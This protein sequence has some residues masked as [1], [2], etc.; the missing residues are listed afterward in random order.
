MRLLLLITVLFYGF[1]GFGQVPRLI[2]YQGVARDFMGVPIANSE[3]TIQ[4]S[5]HDNVVVV[6]TETQQTL[7][8]QLGLFSINVGAIIPLEIDW[9][10]PHL[11][12]KTEF[13]ISPNSSFV[14]LGDEPIGTIPFALMAENI[15]ENPFRVSNWG[16]SLIFNGN[17]FIIIPGL[18]LSNS[19]A[20]LFG[21][22]YLGACN[23]NPAAVYDD[24]SCYFISQPCND[25][26]SATL[27][28][29]INQ[30]CEC[31]GQ[32]LGCTNSSACNFN[33]LASADDGT[34]AGVGFLC[35]DGNANTINDLYQADCSCE[36]TYVIFGC[37]QSNACN[38]NPLANYDNGTC[39][40]A[41]QPCNDNNSATLIDIINQNCECVGQVLGCTN[42]SACNFNPLANTDDGA[43]A[44][45]GFLCNDGN[46]N[47]TNDHYLNDCTC[48]GDVVVLGCMQSNACN[49]NAFANVDNGSC[50][51]YGNTC[52]DGN[53]NTPNDHILSNCECH[54]DNPPNGNG[55]YTPGNG[56][57]DYDGNYYPSV[58][59]GNQEWLASN[60]KTT[61]YCDGTPIAQMQ[62]NTV[63]S[64]ALTPGWCYFNNDP[65]NNLT[66]GKLYNNW[67][68]DNDSLN[69][70]PCGWHMPS[71][72][73]WL[74]LRSFLGGQVPAG[75]KMRSSITWSNNSG[76]NESG[77]N[78]LGGGFRLDNGTFYD[79]P[80][81]SVYWWQQKGCG[82]YWQE[83]PNIS[84]N[85]S[86]GFQMVINNW[87]NW[88]NYIRC[89]K[90]E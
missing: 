25:N 34:C 21:C 5:I 53:P 66:F 59:I 83:M 40:F 58:I 44:G 74:E 60:L 38:F 86:W 8:N 19:N 10:L 87:V 46:A 11:Q 85:N 12:L 76:T 29:I 28:D 67:T 31:V 70:C 88:G 50:L 73:E 56:A 65:N 79:F 37:T 63:W 41:G 47:T 17:Q 84:S 89:V 49:Y 64:N 3:I 90:D 24:G 39:L 75:L 14:L 36:G 61:H 77:F 22:L 7:T 2:P 15:T 72:A 82:W 81:Y 43:C 32:V 52:D 20:N 9:S 68:L 27:I 13:S 4:S 48:M 33:P 35:N 57:F 71:N 78:A 18:S 62:D 1:S 16:D 30:N 26:N 80:T 55:V 54:G 6:Y 23:Y 42:P 45:V 51:F 69:V